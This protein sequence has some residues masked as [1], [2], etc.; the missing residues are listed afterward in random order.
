MTLSYANFVSRVTNG[1][2][3]W[4]LIVPFDFEIRFTAAGGKALFPA[5]FGSAADVQA[6]VRQGYVSVEAAAEFY[7]VVVDPEK[8]EVD[9][10]ATERL[11]AGLR[12]A[13]GAP[14]PA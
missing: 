14:H 5:D 6:D 2:A 11:R 1:G 13:P 12:N 8:F 10:A 4:P 9:D 3:R 7:G